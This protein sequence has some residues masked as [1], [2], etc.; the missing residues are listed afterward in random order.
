MTVL[1]AFSHRFTPGGKLWLA[2]PPSE[3]KWAEC[4]ALP[5]RRYG[6]WPPCAIQKSCGFPHERT[7]STGATMRGVGRI[8]VCQRAPAAVTLP[9]PIYEFHCQACEKDSEVLVRSSRW[10]GTKC[11]RCGSPKLEKK[12]S[13]F[14]SSVASGPA[15]ACCAAPTGRRPAGCGGCCGGGPHHH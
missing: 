6:S 5:R 12:L 2:A 14:A 1:K 11:P 8:G 15:D 13:T 3:N 10:K 7:Q 9:M 4:G